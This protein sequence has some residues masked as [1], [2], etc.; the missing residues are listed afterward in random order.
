MTGRSQAASVTIVRLLDRSRVPADRQAGRQEHAQVPPGAQPDRSL[1][2][3]RPHSGPAGRR[4]RLGDH[5][6]AEGLTRPG[7]ESNW[8]PAPEGDFRPAMRMY[9]PSP[10]IL[11]GDYLL[12]PITE[13]SQT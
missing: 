1:L 7:Q 10:E 6:P 8:L 2:D 5:L 12:P 11:K 4:R 9:Q 13:I 3:R